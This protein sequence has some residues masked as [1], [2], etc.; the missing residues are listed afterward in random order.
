MDVMPPAGPHAYDLPA[1][2]SSKSWQAAPAVSGRILEIG[3]HVH[4]YAVE[5]RLDDVTTGK[6]LW[7]A[8]PD[9]DASGEVVGIPSKGYWWRLG[10]PL[11][12]SHVYR[13]TAAYEN[14]TGK[15]IPDGAMGALGG[16]FLP[17][18][19]DAWP[20]VDR[21]TAEYQR[22]VESTNKGG[23]DMDGM[24]DMQKMPGMP[25]RSS[26]AGSITE[27]S[28]ASNSSLLGPASRVAGTLTSNSTRSLAPNQ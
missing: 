25:A 23:M 1:G 18:R 6:T 19:I 12:R 5:I 20:A 10:L 15:T 13:V 22:D 9:L 11:E 14:P 7:R 2:Q 3:G 4:K 28:S 27:A 8:A 21:T 26:S 16:V 24:D 17:D